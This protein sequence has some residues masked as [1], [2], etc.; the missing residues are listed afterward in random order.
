MT[1]LRRLLVKDRG[2]AR[3][4]VLFSGYWKLGAARI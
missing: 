2:V 4:D 3:T 1:S